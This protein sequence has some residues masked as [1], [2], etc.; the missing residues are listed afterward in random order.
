MSYSSKLMSC[1]L[2]KK[3]RRQRKQKMN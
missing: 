3:R 2:K 1:R